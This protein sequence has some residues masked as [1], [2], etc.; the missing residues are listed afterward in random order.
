MGGVVLVD[1]EAVPE[2]VL[3]RQSK[4]GR[5]G[6]PRLALAI[7]SATCRSTVGVLEEDVFENVT[8]RNNESELAIDGG[9]LSNGQTTTDTGV[10]RLHRIHRETILS[11]F[12]RKSSISISSITISRPR[13]L[14]S[15]CW[16]PR[17]SVVSSFT[18]RSSMVSTAR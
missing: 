6:L 11:G 16:P 10:G 7:D 4:L 9:L 5:P 18:L 8:N 12:Y 1:V 2:T 14:R 17:S 3:D 15:I 13:G